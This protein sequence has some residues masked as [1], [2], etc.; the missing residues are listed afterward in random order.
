[1][2]NNL[3]KLA[4]ILAVCMMLAIAAACNGGAPASTPAPAPAND[5]NTGSSPSAAR[6]YLNIGVFLDSGTLD[7]LFMTGKGGYLSVQRTYAE[8]LW[9]YDAATG[10]RFWVL[11]TGYDH[12]DGLNYRMTL[13]EGVTFSN[14][15]PFTAEDVLFT[16]RL[17]AADSRAYLNVKGIDV[18]RTSVIDD[19]TLDVW[20]DRYEASMEL[21]SVQMQMVDHRT[22]DINTYTSNPVGTGPYTV[23]DY[24][25]N[26]HVT[27]V[28]RD[29]YWGEAPEIKTIYFKCLNELSQ[30]INALETGDVDITIITTR[31]IDHIESLGTVNV[32]VRN[33][34]SSLAAWYNLHDSGPLNSPAAREAVSWAID[35][36]AISNVAF[37][38]AAGLPRLGV[39]ESF[40]ELQDRYFN[41]HPLYSEGFNIERARQLAEQTGLV[42][43]TLRITTNGDPN[44]ITAAEII[45]NGLEQIGV[46]S[47]I[48]NY[49]QSTYFEFMMSNEPEFDIAINQP[50]SPASQPADI[51]GNYPA[52]MPQGW[53]GPERE[54]YM[55]LAVAAN[56]E[57]NVDR[58][59]DVV[60]DLMRMHTDHLLWFGLTE[61]PLIYAYNNNL[62]N[63]RHTLSGLTLFQNIRFA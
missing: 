34:G 47:L 23:T 31:D 17:N 20:L 13:R 60:Y 38:G 61:D 32:E 50:V 37:N 22:Y 16:L 29:D 33:V 27:V 36:Q 12:I 58:R 42:G 39:S 2:K 9:D 41:M 59:K 19:H 7:P 28:A 14:G 55:E 45:Q 1:M 35:R 15:N 25:P 24:V 53:T 57:Q 26:S 56:S 10:E 8:P 21:G 11:A 40:I 30:R 54:R 18:E 49:D 52:F 48:T 3:R 46:N 43:Q 4:A 44:F 62:R 51:Y 6:D 63:V 5:G